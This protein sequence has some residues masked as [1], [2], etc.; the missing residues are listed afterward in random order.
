[1][2]MALAV[3]LASLCV[4]PPSS[5]QA[6]VPK[7]AWSRDEAFNAM[8]RGVTNISAAESFV[9]ENAAVKKLL[10]G[11]AEQARSLKDI[12]PEQKKVAPEYLM[13]LTLNAYLVEKAAALAKGADTHQEA[14]TILKEVNE[15]LKTKK[16]YGGK[17]ADVYGMV[18]VTVNTKKNG[19]D[20]GG[21]MVFYVPKALAADKGQYRK[22]D[23]ESTPTSK[24]L[25]AGNYL[26]WTTKNDRI[27]EKTPV[28][29]GDDKKD[30]MEVDIPAP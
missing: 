7:K 29:P 13:S 28:S 2:R 18:E 22:F 17:Y 26:F 16:R 25:A 5:L 15:D 27:G 19:T 12:V 21:C 6:Q 14:V 10:D 24:K 4:V 1:M 20:Q 8:L 30:K 9:K 23:K 3:A 11:I